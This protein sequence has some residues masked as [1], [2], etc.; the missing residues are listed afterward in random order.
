MKKP[1]ILCVIP[2]R[3]NST[4]LPNKP[5]ILLGNKPM[6]QWV[7]EG[8]CSCQ[9]FSKVIVATDSE[10]I[11]E[12]IQKIGG[13]VEMTPSELPTGT[14]RVG[15]V[16]SKYPEYDVV[17]NL[18]G[19]EPF[20]QA[21]MLDALVEP[22]FNGINPLMATLACPIKMEEEYLDP[23]TVKVIYN[24]FDFAIYFSRAPIPFFRQQQKSV[25]ISMHLGLYAFKRDYLMEFIKLE[26][27]PLEQC[28]VL[29]QLRAIENGVSI[30]V[31]HTP[32]RIIE[33]NYPHD[34]ELAKKFLKDKGFA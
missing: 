28:E 12:V 3:L 5:L 24:K 17:V 16:A 25:P 33:I 23:N 15:Y 32:H 7:Y 34:L 20:I 21:D 31:S 26:Q 14:D 6:I 11:A 27:T 8:A 4:R 30:Y 2:S 9:K 10:K 1:N 18:Q 22:Y 29:E 13:Q 19:D